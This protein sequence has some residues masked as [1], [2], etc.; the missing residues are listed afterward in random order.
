[1]S[2]S[3]K[4][5]FKHLF[6][7]FYNP[8]YKILW[9][10]NMISY[11]SRWTQLI[12]SNWIVLEIT[13]SPFLVSLVAFCGTIPLFFIGILG[14]QFA[15]Q[16]PR[17]KLLL[18][19]ASASLTASLIILGE[20]ITNSIEYWHIYISISIIG[21]SWAIDMPS[22][23]SLI[24]DFMDGKPIANG[25]AL[26]SIGISLA[27]MIGPALA[28]VLM[29]IYGSISS[30]A[31]ICIF[32]IISIF[33]INLIPTTTQSN[34]NSKHQLLKIQYK[35]IFNLLKTYPIIIPTIFLTIVMNL[36][37]F[38]YT[39]I[40][41]VIAKNTL[42]LEHDLMGILQATPGIGAMIGTILICSFTKL[43]DHYKIYSNGC[44]IAFLGVLCFAISTNFITSSFILILVGLGTAGFASM[45]STIILTNTPYNKRGLALGLI[46]I[47]I[48]TGPFGAL[49]I[50]QIA[51]IFNPQNALILNSLLGLTLTILSI[52]S[53]KIKKITP[54]N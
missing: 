13:N 26:D 30:L 33:S 38:P 15:D 22:R 36:L 18:F 45:Q 19:T 29:S 21:I 52:I 1:M 43:P 5:S 27:T 53:L 34:Q 10:S 11:Q 25:V 39:F 14:G 3:Q 37:M 2:Y 44:L 35:E 31:L 46:T 48:G 7:P 50:G 32:Y 49:F 4:I 51:E 40:L 28:G 42:G 9:F 6:D 24:H 20:I 54:S 41:P 17:K 47:A 12:V 23:R 16:L 8:K